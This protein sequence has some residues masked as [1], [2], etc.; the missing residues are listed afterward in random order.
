MRQTKSVLA[1]LLTL[2]MLLGML[3]GTA[4]AAES[5]AS[6]KIT[7][8]EGRTCTNGEDGETQTAVYGLKFTTTVPDGMK[9]CI[10]L[11]AYD[12]EKIQAV[13]VSNI[14]GVD[15]YQ[16]TNT[17]DGSQ[18]KACFDVTGKATTGVL[19]KLFDTTAASWR[20]IDGKT[21]VQYSVGY[22]GTVTNKTETQDMFNF[23]YRLQEGTDLADLTAGSIQ[24]ITDPD[25]DIYKAHFNVEKDG[26]DKGVWFSSTNSEEYSVYAGTASLSVTHPGSGNKDA[27]TGTEASKPT[28]ASKKGG[29]VTLETRTVDGETVEYAYG[30]TD[31][32]PTSAWQDGTSFTG[33][34]AGKYYFF[35]RVKETADH[36]AGTAVASDSVT[37]YAA[38]SISYAE[39]P[40]MTIDT[41]I[42]SLS[43]TVGNAGAGA[44]ETNAYQI[45]A[46]TLP[47]GLSIDDETGVIS[48]TPTTAGVEGEVTVTYTDAEGQI[49]TAVVKYGA[50]NKMAGNLVISCADTGYGTAPNPQVS[51]N[52]NGGDVTYTYS[53]TANGT[54]GEWD[55]KNPVGTYYVKGTAAATDKYEAAVSEPVAFQVTAAAINGTV[56]ISGDAVYGKTLT[57]NPSDIPGTLAYQWYRGEAAIDG[58]TAST[59][60][61]TTDDVGSTISVKVS[62]SAGN[63]GG[64]VNSDPTSAVA[65]ATYSS[66]VTGAATVVSST[67]DKNETSN[68]TWALSG[69]S[70]LPDDIA[71]VGYGT[72]NIG[73]NTDSLISGTPAV[74]GGSLKYTVAPKAA[75]V[76]ATITVVVTSANYEDITATI[77]VTSVD[78]QPATV[79]LAGSTV[80]YDG[81]AHALTPVWPTVGTGTTTKTVTYTKGGAVTEE[82]PKDAGTYTVT[83]TYENDTHYGTATATLTIE[84]L[85]AVLSWSGDTGLVY[86]GDAKNVT[87]TVSN[88]VGDDSCTVTVTGGGAVNAGDHTATAASLSNPNYKLPTAKTHAYT[89]APKVV[90]NLTVELSANSF[91]YNEQEQQPTVIAVKDGETELTAGDYAV[92]IPNSTN[93]GTYKVTVT[94]TGGNYKGSTGE[95]EYRITK[96]LQS[97]LTI[98]DTSNKTYGDAAFVIT[99]SGGNG[100]GAVTLTS[101]DPT[102]LKLEQGEGKWTA[103][104]LKAGTVTLTA[105][106]AGDDNYEPA[107]EKTVEVTIARKSL[108][109]A[110]IVVTLEKDSFVY[111]GEAFTPAVTVKDGDKTLVKDTDYEVA[112]TDNT[113]AGTAKVTVTGKGNYTESVEKKFTINK[114]SLAEKTP[115]IVGEAKVGGVLTAKLDGV[116]ADQ[117]TWTWYRNGAA[118]DGATAASYVVTSA[119]SNKDITVK[120][121]AKEVNYTGTT[122]SS[123]PVRVAKQ[124]ITGT[125][126]I[127]AAG[128]IAKDTV[129]TANVDKI[130]PAEAK[131]GLTYQW[132]VDGV[133][134]QGAANTTYT[135]LEADAEKSITVTVTA[136]GDYDG[137]ITSA[138]VEVGKTPLTGTVTL[139][140]SDGK[141]TATVTAPADSY[142]IVWLRDGQVISGATGTEYT[143][144]DADKGHTI[145]AKLVAKGDTYTG[146]VVAASG[147]DVSS[148][149]P[150]APTVTASA[151]NGQVTVSWTVSDN[152]GAPITSYTVTC[153]VKNGALVETVT[154]DATTTS[155]TFTGLTN[156]TPYTVT[157]KAINAEGT[158]TA[159]SATATPTAPSGGGSIGGGGGV[160]T[161]A[162]TVEK[163]ENGSVTVSPKNASKGATVTLTVTPDEG[164]VLDTITVTDKNGNAIEVTKVSDGK[165]TFKMPGAPVTVKASFTEETVESK[166]SFTDV[167]ENAWYYDAV[168]YVY[169]NGMMTG[170]NDGTTFSPSMSLS[171]SMMAQVLYNLEKGTA[172]ATGSFTDVAA[173]AWY[174]DAVNWAAANGIVGGYGNGKFGPEDSITRE[175]MALILYNYANFKGYDMT[176]TTD[177]TSFSDDEKVSDWA[178]YAMKWAVAEGLINGSNNALNPLGT[179]SRAEVAQILMNFGQNVANL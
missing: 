127:S 110:G 163:T 140:Q 96:K 45:T 66:S 159:G 48:G 153:N 27:Y 129:L 144:T 154:L 62:D 130:M 77:T 145:S 135:V 55:T 87:A 21:T 179:A 121:V 74:E 82:A 12:P 35:A 15:Y 50:V 20:T 174:A 136:T 132:Y 141:I 86:N 137:S 149:A 64:T 100:T 6:L 19:G 53:T 44:A 8:I 85:E 139:S 9:G 97:G 56:T 118:I 104:I 22:A 131:A 102:I 167:A 11:L 73:E 58:A 78:K 89:I 106:K 40:T 76:T 69:L 25:S 31:D 125:V 33:L 83:A 166:L 92:T 24:V 112:Y 98:S 158:S 28:V 173:G 84:Q 178:E 150:A 54:Y 57:A 99:V 138:A 36:Q 170:T 155:Y 30:T 171:R 49:A 126:V 13:Q 116:A 80:T 156:D 75:D 124:A 113:A 172:P 142:D 18:D 91:V 79:T 26:A 148:T 59:Y 169:E 63:Y 52:T 147:I 94:V 5:D 32:A 14:E 60:T 38:P 43:P 107:D 3:P 61:L 65:K 114:A 67:Y 115:T 4:W 2:C 162:T 95:A 157:V 103:T 39:I 51:T 151:G 42:T 134:V 133:A 152:G 168:A 16:D 10:V 143:V 176:A 46:G 119:D 93:V 108:E 71:N 41:A 72:V 17:S 1:L 101:S 23:Y 164:Y 177:L 120:A 146:E 34:P 161:Y 160:T 70:G 109:A 81:Q 175:Q 68:Y 29:D 128:P 123:E 88:L 37:V 111:T 47:A 165:Y 7:S 122:L 90:N 105:N 117:Y